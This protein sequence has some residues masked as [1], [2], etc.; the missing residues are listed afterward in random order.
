MKI[1]VLLALRS[2]SRNRRRTTISL[3][4]VGFGVAALI[5]AG[6]FVDALLVKLRED[7]I[8]SQLGHIQIR[9]RVQEGKNPFAHLLP[10]SPDAM[11]PVARLPGVKLVTP[12]L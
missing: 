12:R 4:T 6:G 11:A 1:V 2:L 7:T 10:T 5:V 8:H 3:C 9:N